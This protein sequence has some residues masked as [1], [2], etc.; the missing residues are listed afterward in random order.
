MATHDYVIDNQSAPNFRSDLND[1]LA[2]IVSTNSNASAPSVTFANMLWYDTTNNQLKKRNET[3]SDP[4]IVLGTIDEGTGKFTPNAAI[5]TSEIAAATLVTSSDTIASNDNDTTIPTSAAV[6]DYTDQYLILRSV[7]LDTSLTGT[8]QNRALGTTVRNTISGASVSSPT[9]TLPAGKYLFRTSASAYQTNYHYIRL[10]NTTDSTDTL[11]G[12]MAYS[13]N[14]SDAHPTISLIDSYFEI[15]ATKNFQIQHFAD[16]GGKSLYLPGSDGV[17][18][19]TL[20]VI[21]QKIN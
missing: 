5:T 2:A 6:I 11:V 14:D 19:Q 18:Q 10:R 4:W 9:F 17:N 21:V 13:R 8:F 16:V 3:N 7:A 20:S 1:A 12:S 15:A